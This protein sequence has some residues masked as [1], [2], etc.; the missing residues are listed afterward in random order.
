[1]FRLAFVLVAALVG[2]SGAVNAQY[3]ND[4]P[5]GPILGRHGNHVY[6]IVCATCSIWQDYRNFAWNQLSINGGDSR[7]P[8]NPNH[9]TTFRIYT[10]S[11]TDIYPATVEVTLEIEVVEVMGVRVGQRP[12]DG[13]HYIVETHPEN[14]DNVPAGFYPGGMG[15]LQFPYQPPP[16]EDDASGGS[17]GGSSGSGSGGGGGDSPSG[18][19][20]GWGG[21]GGGAGAGGGFGGGYGG[22]RGGYCGA[23]TDYVCIQF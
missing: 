4:R 11:A 8:N 15:P 10:D 3:S 5:S 18:G 19:G 23:G 22:G 13:R 9:V 21:G 14:G 7:T 6:P 2:W 16:V 17:G 12:V 1:M 20:G